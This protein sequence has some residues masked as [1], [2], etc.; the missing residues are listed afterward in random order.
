MGENVYSIS[1]LDS[2][3]ECIYLLCHLIY[4]FD[5]LDKYTH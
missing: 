3:N 4:M 1:R 2:I 5:T